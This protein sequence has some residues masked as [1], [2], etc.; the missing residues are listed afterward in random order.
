MQLTVTDGSA[1]VAGQTI[2]LRRGAPVPSYT[3]ADPRRTGALA[4]AIA[5]NIIEV[6]HQNLTRSPRIR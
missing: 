2:V 3:T 1:G 6:Q 4:A 5:L